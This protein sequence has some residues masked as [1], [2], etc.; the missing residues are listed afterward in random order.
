MGTRSNIGMIHPDGTFEVI[1]CHYD[2]YL[3]GVGKTLQNHYT[4][5]LKVKDLL[6]LGDICTLGERTTPTPGSGHTY[7][8][9]EKGVCKAF[10]RDR[11]ETG[12]DARTYP[13]SGHYMADM[14]DDIDIEF[15]YVFDTREN[16]PHDAWTVLRQHD[17]TVDHKGDTSL[18]PR[19]PVMTLTKALAID[20]EHE[21]MRVNNAGPQDRY[22]KPLTLKQAVTL[23]KEVVGAPFPFAM[24]CYDAK[25]ERGIFYY[26]EGEEA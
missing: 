9:P 1:Y 17:V 3:S 4:D 10:R 2:G 18:H 21:A 24:P 6:A 5:K 14:V 20:K 15:I 7:D 8:D 12:V 16:N 11:G 25:G 13:S 26:R 19:L 22:G 23:W